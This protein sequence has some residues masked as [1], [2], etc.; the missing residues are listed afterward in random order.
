MGVGLLFEVSMAFSTDSDLANLIPDILELGINS[1][2]EEHAKAQADIERTLRIKWWPKKRL[3]LSEPSSYAEMDATK[4]VATQFMT[5]SV[6]LVLWRYVLPQLTNWVEG[7]RF[8]T[9][10]DFYKARYNEELEAVL[11]DGVEYDADGS[12][13]IT[14]FEKQSQHVNRLDR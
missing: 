6:Y 13:T 5:T 14:D 10:I 12:G 2:S 11:D 1:F 3:S 7:D 9:M 8:S 4:L